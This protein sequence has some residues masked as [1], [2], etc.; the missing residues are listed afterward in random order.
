MDD[1]DSNV[2][3]ETVFSNSEKKEEDGDEARE[4]VG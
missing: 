2:F 4:G 3:K 1:Y